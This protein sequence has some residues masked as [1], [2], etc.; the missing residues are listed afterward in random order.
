MDDALRF[1]ER[2]KAAGVDVRCEVFPEMQHVWHF[3][4]GKAPEA[5]DAIAKLAAWVKPKL[6]L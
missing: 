3:M 1:A 4:A 6:G 5:D 2:A